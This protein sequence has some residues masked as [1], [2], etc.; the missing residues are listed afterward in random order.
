MKGTSW[1]VCGRPPQW[2]VGLHRAPRFLN[3][4]WLTPL[5]AGFYRAIPL[6]W[7]PA[8]P[9]QAVLGAHAPHK[10]HLA[11]VTLVPWGEASSIPT[12][13]RRFR[14]MVGLGLCL[15]HAGRLRCLGLADAAR[16]NHRR[17][18]PSQ[19]L[20]ALHRPGCLA[21]RPL[22][23]ARLSALFSPVHYQLA[24]NRGH[25]ARFLIVGTCSSFL[26]SRKKGQTSE[27]PLSPTE[28]GD[29]GVR[30]DE[31]FA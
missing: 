2:K 21:R 4:S 27:N 11:G 31:D 29:L 1:L 3:G 14:S 6:R 30:F 23:P 9:E 8:F 15:A 24:R 19:T 5:S 17:V 22:F 18:S 10:E 16:A 7:L 13:G 20:A 26:L 28:R 12:D 25:L